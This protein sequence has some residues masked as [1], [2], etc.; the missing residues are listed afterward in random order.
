MAFTALN[1]ARGSITVAVIRKFMLLI[2]LIYL[3]P[4]RRMTTVHPATDAAVMT[5]TAILFAIQFKKS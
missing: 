1:R 2:S 5:F 4:A 3:L